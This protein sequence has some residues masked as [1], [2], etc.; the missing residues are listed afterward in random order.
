MKKINYTLLTV[1]VIAAIPISCYVFRYAAARIN[2]ASVCRGRVV[3]SE[4]G[5]IQIQTRYYNL[6]CPFEWED[7]VSV[8][9]QPMHEEYGGK[10]SSWE[11]DANNID[12]DNYSLTILYESDNKR[13]V[14]GELQMYGYLQ[15]CQDLYNWDYAGYLAIQPYDH[16]GYTTRLI[17]QYPVIDRQL[18]Y[19]DVYLSMR[20]E[21][22][23]IVE[24]LEPRKSFLLKKDQYTFVDWYKNQNPGDH[25]QTWEEY[26][27]EERRRYEEQEQRRM[28]NN[29]NALPGLQDSG[30]NS[31]GY[32][33]Y[34][35]HGS[36]GY[37]PDPY[38]VY[39]YDDPED[40]ADDWADEFSDGGNDE[41]EAW[42]EAYGYWEDN[43]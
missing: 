25:G 24:N 39:E 36:S 15:D 9:V 35:S 13:A 43:N 41:D 23:H 22:P 16:R 4:A 34:Y 37:N 29:Q 20:S 6:N 2:D 28:E 12:P 33:S 30:G 8:E 40:F 3:A 17:I 42:D 5:G 26:Y 21:L 7:K 11:D 27:E 18:L 1:G 31:S 38:D 32:G 10:D 19:D 14:V